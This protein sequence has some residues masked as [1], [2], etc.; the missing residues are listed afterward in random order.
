[1]SYLII[2]RGPLGVGK[3][4]IA[5]KLANKLKAKYLSVD[6][7]LEKYKLGYD[8][9]DGNISQKSFLKT[10]EVLA[11]K[12]K[13]FLNKNIPVI[14]DGNFYWPSHIEDLI[15][16]LSIKYYIFNLYAPL[17]V[18]IKRDEK[19]EKTYGLEAVKAVYKRSMELEYGIV[20]NTTKSEDDGVKQIV[21]YL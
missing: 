7:I 4:T 11:P 18:C 2:I 19:R 6:K 14:F 21:S 17:D 16:K 12:A 8:I 20:I 1:M 15:K 9:E 13:E 3:T 10:N 5:K